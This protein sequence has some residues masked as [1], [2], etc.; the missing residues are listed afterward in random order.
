MIWAVGCRRECAR[1][2]RSLLTEKFG[3]VAARLGRA[4]ALEQPCRVEPANHTKAARAT[5]PRRNGSSVAAVLRW[6][7]KGQKLLY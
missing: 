6:A 5:P 4:R 7:C 1:A 2:V 3:C